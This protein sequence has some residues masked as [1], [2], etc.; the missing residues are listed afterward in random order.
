MPEQTLKKS[1]TKICEACGA[2]FSCGAR[3]EKCWCFKIELSDETLGRLEKEYKSCLCAQC[4]EK[5]LQ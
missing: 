1:E 2:D 5:T 3:A 4:L